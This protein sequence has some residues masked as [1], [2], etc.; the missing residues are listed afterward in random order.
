MLF[1]V[2]SHPNNENQK[3]HYIRQK[4]G[5]LEIFF[6]IQE[7]LKILQS[8]TFLRVFLVTNTDD[9][10]DKLKHLN[11]NIILQTKHQLTHAVRTVTRS[12]WTQVFVIR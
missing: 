12:H 7:I 11:S 4:E 2:L 9:V 10:S 5:S 6:K 8:E 1:K 3:F